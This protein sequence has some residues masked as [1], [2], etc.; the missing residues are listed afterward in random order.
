MNRYEVLRT[1]LKCETFQ[2]NGPSDTAWLQWATTHVPLVSPSTF[3][4]TGRHL[5]H[6]CIGSDPEFA[7][8]AGERDRVEAYALGLKVGLAVGCD[9]NERLVEL[10]PWPDVSVVKHVAGILT[11]LRWM[12]RTYGKN[13]KGLGCRAGAFFAGDGMGGHVHFGRKR[14]TRDAEVAALDGLA[15]VLKAT[16]IFPIREWEYR[17]RGDQRRQRYGLP[18]DMRPQRHGYE[19]R[20]LPSWLQSPTIAFIVLAASKL[21]VLDP[22]ISATWRGK[23]WTPEAAADLLR[24]LAKLYRGRDDDA[25]IL[26]HL[27]TRDGNRVFLVD[28]AADFALAWGINF[29]TPTLDPGEPYI[30]PACIEPNPNEINEIQDHLLHGTLLGFKEYPANFTWK[31]PDVAY[32]WV[33]TQVQPGRHAGFG[34]LIHNLVTS[35]TLYIAWEFSNQNEF[36]VAGYIPLTWTEEEK[37]LLRGYYANIQII[38]G[39][40]DNPQ[41]RIV[42]PKILCT[43]ENVGA[44]R[45][46]LLKTGL[47]PIWTVE[48]VRATSVTE[49]YKERPE[50]KTTSKWR[51]V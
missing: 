42:I 33:P 14:P 21:V 18:G 40:Y 34:D 29:N 45:D 11:A 17:M 5:N 6:F 50:A 12:H 24:G 46:T 41:T 49:W 3:T 7:F 1:I 31:L 16:G 25:Y 51:K 28:H 8:A 23:I 39:A 20:S 37:Q 15:G 10:R 2:P 22:T 32:R 19:Y 48:S 26:Y 36:V 44:L 35:Q 9:Q 4:A 47:F 13:L 43:T 27:L 38:N 30:L